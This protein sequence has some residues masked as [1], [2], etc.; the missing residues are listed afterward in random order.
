MERAEV[1]TLIRL[2]SLLLG[3]GET[4][5]H[6]VGLDFSQSAKERRKAAVRLV[7]KNSLAAPRGVQVRMARLLADLLARPFPHDLP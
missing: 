4:E 6:L 1:S 2:R 5:S 7:N 3:C